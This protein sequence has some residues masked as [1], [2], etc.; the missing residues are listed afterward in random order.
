LTSFDNESQNSTVLAHDAA[1]VLNSLA[2]M[3]SETPLPG[4]SGGLGI[5]HFEQHPGDGA[6]SNFVDSL[7]NGNLKQPDHSPNGGGSTKKGRSKACEECRKSKVSASQI[8]FN[9]TKT[10]KAF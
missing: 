10:L 3:G 1:S 8:N 6:R 9:E 4:V 7:H 5:T 2:S